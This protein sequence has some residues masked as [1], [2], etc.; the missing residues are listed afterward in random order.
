MLSTT[1]TN[2]AFTNLIE[3]QSIFKID[4]NDI[5]PHAPLVSDFFQFLAWNVR[6]VATFAAYA[7]VDNISK[8][9]FKIM[10]YISRP[11]IHG[12]NI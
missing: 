9:I 11:C 4:N 2:K 8:H 6:C 5:R 1:C 7:V 10:I 12:V 3:R